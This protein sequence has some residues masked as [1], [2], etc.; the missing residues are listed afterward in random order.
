MITLRAHGD[1]TGDFNDMGYSARHDIAAAVQFLERRLPGN[2]IVVHGLSMGG[3]AALFASREL[4]NRVSGYIL[5]SPYRDLRV[6]ARNRIENALPPVLDYVA[7]LGFLVVSPL[8]LPDL[9]KI[10]PVKAVCGIPDDVPVLILAGG[11]DPV[12]RPHE[13]QAILD[14]VRSHGRLVLF[15]RAGHMNFPETSPD[16]YQQSMNGFLREIKRRHRHSP[17][18]LPALP[19]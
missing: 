8:V 17:G 7:Y 14:R 9:A 5:E 16:V 6:A 1:S 10:S 19:H 4:G 12:A 13:A 2:A 15:E 3:A 18:G 11:E